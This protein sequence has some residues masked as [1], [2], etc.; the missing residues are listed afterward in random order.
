MKNVADFQYEGEAIAYRNEL[1]AKGLSAVAETYSPQHTRAR[2]VVR[3]PEEQYDSFIPGN[4]LTYPVDD[5]PTVICPHCGHTDVE[6]PAPFFLGCIGTAL[7]VPAIIYLVRRK[8]D[9][10][11]YICNHCR[12]T[13]RFRL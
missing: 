13:F 5:G 7:I 3:V 6:Q 8:R 9:G 4:I 2:F 11:F 10:I 12:K 1:E